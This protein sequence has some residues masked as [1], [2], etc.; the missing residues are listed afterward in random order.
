MS[1]SPDTFHIMSTKTELHVIVAFVEKIPTL[2]SISYSMR[3]RVSPERV[4]TVTSP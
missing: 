2:L 1:V 4:I 3:T